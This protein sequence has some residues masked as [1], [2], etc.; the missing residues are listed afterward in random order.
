MRK[1][2]IVTTALL[3][4]SIL[5]NVGLWATEKSGTVGVNIRWEVD[6]E[7]TIT[8]TGSG[9]IPDYDIFYGTPPAWTQ[10]MV[11]KKLVLDPNITRIGAYAFINC[12]IESIDFGTG[13]GQASKLESI[14]VCAF[15][16]CYKLTADLVIPSGVTTIEQSAFYN[17]KAIK[18]VTLPATLTTL[19]ER[20]FHDCYLRSVTL[21]ATTPPAYKFVT[22]ALMS[23][24]AIYIPVESARAYQ[25]ADYWSG[26]KSQLRVKDKRVYATVTA[27]Y[28]DLTLTMYYDNKVSA[29]DDSGLY[30]YEFGDTFDGQKLGT[31]MHC[32]TSGITTVCF[33]ESIADYRP[34][35]CAG[36][37]YDFSRLKT[38]N[39]L[40]RL[41]TESVK[42]MRSMFS[43]CS[44]LTS[45][46]LS[47]LNTANVEDM[48]AMFYGCKSMK[49]L[50]LG[51]LNTARVTTMA[52]MFREC[53]SLTS[54]NLSTFDTYNVVDM[55][56]MFRDCSSIETLDL[57]T[58]DTHKLINT[59]GM[60]SGASALKNIYVSRNFVTNNIT[61]SSQMFSGNSYLTPGD[62]TLANYDTNGNFLHKVGTLDGE[63]L[64]EKGG[65]L[66]IGELHLDDSREMVLTEGTAVSKAT[67]S[68]T[69]NSKWGTIC[70][71][72]FFKPDNDLYGIYRIKSINADEITLETFNGL[73]SG[74]EAYII[75]RKT[76]DNTLSISN[77]ENSTNLSTPYG[78]R[79]RGTYTTQILDDA[80][81]FIANDAFRSV[82]YYK[83]SGAK[84]VKVAPYHAYIKNPLPDVQKASVLRIN[85]GQATGIDN[86]TI[87][88]A[89][90]VDDLNNAATEIYTI[91]GHRTDCLQK[92][93][94][95][96]KTG[97]KTRKVIVK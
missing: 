55:M 37:F 52:H 46:D 14:G 29:Y 92:G 47:T 21:L 4:L 34:T 64:C 82:A 11:I 54:L 56:N 30:V 80:D 32:N 61:G 39:N 78:S 91:D 9:E 89:T 25:K 65:R 7:G 73:A 44:S 74:G 20:A 71:P 58:F 96:V 16:N 31:D 3:L 94:N 42:S 66:T 43:G 83:A 50:D 19:D 24:A 72:F 48:S 60:F 1:R 28:G 38:I 87:D 77:D 85:D 5:T 10:E 59:M 84:G 17:C 67:Y 81:Y 69:M 12:D 90:I 8:F 22:D 93:L 35:T 76:D 79:L 68:R 62:K 41:N 49:S 88:N 36:W 26:L 70:L 86:A 23:D 53:S 2:L 75:Y 40:D 15:N 57:S 18:N 45:L 63:T 6:D 27:G 97:G 33:D 51:T 95:I 13:S